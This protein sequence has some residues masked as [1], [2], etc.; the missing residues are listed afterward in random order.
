MN[1]I[2]FPFSSLYSK[3]I[4]VVRQ[5]LIWSGVL[6]GA[7]S[8]SSFEQGQPAAPGEQNNIVQ[9]RRE[10]VSGFAVSD[11]PEVSRAAI[12]ILSNGGNAVDAAAAMMFHLSVVLPSRAGVMGGGVC[13][14]YF[15]EEERA[16]TLDFLSPAFN[17]DRGAGLPSLPRGAFYMQSRYGRQ[18]WSSVLQPALEATKNA[19]VSGAFAQDLKEYATAA[20]AARSSGMIPFQ[21]VSLFQ[22]ENGDIFEEGDS[23]SQP[24][25]GRLLNKMAVNGTGILY[26]GEM[27]EEFLKDALSQGYALPEEQLKQYRPKMRDSETVK[28]EKGVVFL[29]NR[30]ISGDAGETLAKAF[31][32]D[33]HA[34]AG[35]AGRVL[36]NFSKGRVYPFGLTDGTSFVV[37]D[38][39]GMTA[40]C[41]LSVG[42]LFGTGVYLPKEGVFL[43]QPLAQ[44]SA[45]FY[46]VLYPKSEQEGK[47]GISYASAAVGTF[48]FA[49]QM[50]LLKEIFS[51]GYPLP[52][53]MKTVG[54][55]L[56]DEEEEKAFMERNQAFLCK[57]D[58]CILSSDFRGRGAGVFLEE[59]S[60]VASWEL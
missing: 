53:A 33:D 18:S 57:G 35:K 17:P 7:V 47:T 39:S 46:S 27:A 44:N 5:S 51:E 22:K 34:R 43:A 48:A 15:P 37:Q 52:E 11:V 6:F 14:I 40:V 9:A 29:Q 24:E 26:N 23:F 21:P 19:S 42:R 36:D 54:Q 49:D 1:F 13:Q 4:S 16:K 32:G 60:P 20:Q 12:R 58:I 56:T 25:L 30:E 10:Q 59:S 8:C 28:T 41:G 3:S 55:R 31:L 45:S 38:E 2:K 50:R